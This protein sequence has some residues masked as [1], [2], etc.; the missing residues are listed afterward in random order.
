MKPTL[1]LATL[2]AIG[3][4]AYMPLPSVAQT[5]FSIVVGSPPPPARFESVPQPRHGYAWAPGYWDWNGHRHEWV[6]GRW[7]RARHGYYY[8]PAEWR[9]DGGGYRLER[10]GWIEVSGPHMAPPPPRYEPV[11]HARRGYVW[12]PGHWEWRGNRHEWIG[13][14]WIAERSRDA[15]RPHHWHGRDGRWHPERPQWTGH[16]RDRDHDGI[17]DHMERRNRFDRDR[18][19]IDDRYDRDRDNDG[20]ANHRDADRDGDG[21]RNEYDRRPDNNRR[22]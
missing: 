5:S 11:P 14:V 16:G 9:R 12:E 22:Y 21:V 10:G 18:D 1:T 8:Q 4:A 6:S 2:I 17:P 20:I 15:Y 19:G 13:G 7:E 3:A